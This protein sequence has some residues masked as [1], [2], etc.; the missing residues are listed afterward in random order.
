MKSVPHDLHVLQ[1]CHSYDGP[2]LDVARQYIALFDGTGISV[3]TVF[4][5]GV[6]KRDIEHLIGSKAIFLNY[7]S[8]QL[9][10]LKLGPIRDIRRVAA[11]GRFSMCIAH[12]FKPIYIA[13]L[14][15][16]LPVVGV[17]HA[18]GGYRRFH[19]RLFAR[20]FRSRLHLLGVS[21][22]VRDDMRSLLPG[23]SVD[24]LYN[25]L[26]VEAVCSRQVSRE[27]ARSHLGLP[28]DAWIV[29]N[30]GRL[31]PD[32]DQE[33]LLRGFALALPKLPENSLVVIVGQGRLE[34]D[35]RS[36]S[37]ELGL[38]ERT[39]FMGQVPE[40]RCYFKAFD[41]F[42]LTS[43]REPFGMV[44]LEAMAAGVPII[45]SDC[46]GAPEIVGG[47]ARLFP[48]QDINALADLLVDA[49]SAGEED[50][51]ARVRAA[52]RELTERF[53][54]N[55]AR[56]AFATLNFFNDALQNIQRRLVISKEARR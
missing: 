6:P 19:R 30:V 28:S 36:L 23:L 34:Q 10:G 53:S 27:E 11:Q 25:R 21:E 15:T 24:T 12:R 47:F 18:F 4:L 3:T 5:T 40:V 48:F 22:A 55:A 50:R 45:A 2:F 38:A 35:L 31:H 49:A 39:V 44:L 56:N 13:C 17:H 1:V 54:D 16:S 7:R 52:E 26:K 32:K 29:G 51:A 8:R 33:T 14:G 20:M 37:Q 9:R 43:D 41:V 42:A 46:G